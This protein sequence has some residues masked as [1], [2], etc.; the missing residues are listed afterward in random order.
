MSIGICNSLHY[1]TLIDRM[2]EEES[3]AVH[4]HATPE[5]RHT[6]NESDTLQQCNVPSNL[7]KQDV[8]CSTEYSC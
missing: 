3:S 1:K 2:L 5:Y 7:V 4:S 6:S 8:K